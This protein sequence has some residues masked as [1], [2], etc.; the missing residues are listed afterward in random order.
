[1]AVRKLT[2]D[3]VREIRASSENNGVLSRRY[4]I[5]APAI[6]RIRTGETYKRVKT[7]VWVENA[8]SRSRQTHQRV[9]T[10]EQVAQMR[11]KFAAGESLTHLAIDYGV[12]ITC[13]GFILDGKTYKDAGG[14]IR[15]KA[16]T[17]SYNKLKPEH[18]RRMRA[19]YAEG[20]TIEEMEARW[21]LTRKVVRG[22]VLGHTYCEVA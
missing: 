22:V 2:D 17:R 4:G 5:N 18:V 20:A 1:M 3:Q 8:C 11:E 14:P 7:P 15:V 19:E 10:N 6:Q 21:R 12:T 13:V 16:G 9:F